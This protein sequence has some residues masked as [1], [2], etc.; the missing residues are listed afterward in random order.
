MRSQPSILSLALCT[1]SFLLAGCRNWDLVEA[2]LRTRD[3]EVRE[4]R[5]ELRRLECHNE[6]LQRETEALRQGGPRFSPEQAAQTFGLK[7]IVLGRLTG[8]YDNDN[9]PG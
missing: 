8:G 9:C 5:E 6:A 7:Q 2:E 3:R 4:L 1:W